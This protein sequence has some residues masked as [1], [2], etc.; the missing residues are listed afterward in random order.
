MVT[1]NNL[2]PQAIKRLW[3]GVCT[4]TVHTNTTD[5][6]TGRTAVG[7]VDTYTNEPCLLL[8]KNITTTDP[9][10]NA[11]RTA[12][13]VTLMVDPA[14]AIPPGSKITVVQN[15]FTGVYEQSGVP[16]VYSHHKEI[17]LALFKGWA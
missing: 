14:V 4:V 6:S 13:S 7:E 10:D 15:G 11:E 9:T 1:G 5:E 17:P 16:A 3:E 8:F 12:Q 2:Y